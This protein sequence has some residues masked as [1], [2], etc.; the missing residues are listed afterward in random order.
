MM[1]MRARRA[2]GTRVAA[3]QLGKRVSYVLAM[4]E[5][6]WWWRWGPP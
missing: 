2:M 5:F 4:K 6:R 1:R 3:Q